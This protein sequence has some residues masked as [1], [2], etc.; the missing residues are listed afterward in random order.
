MINQYGYYYLNNQNS[1][2]CQY[3]CKMI[4]EN[5][6]WKDLDSV[7]TFDEAYLV[8][9]LLQVIHLFAKCKDQENRYQYLKKHVSKKVLKQNLLKINSFPKTLE[10]L[11]YLINIKLY[12][13]LFSGF[14]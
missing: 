9:Y 5:L 13:K 12:L 10:G 11:I 4:E 2:T 7:Y 8:L 14:F 3:T 1:L 6:Y